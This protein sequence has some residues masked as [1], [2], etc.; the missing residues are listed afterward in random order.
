MVGFAAYEESGDAILPFLE[1][2]EF[3]G[4]VDAS[5]SVFFLMLGSSASFFEEVLVG[6]V[7]VGY[8]IA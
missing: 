6:V 3:S 7:P 2:E 5:S 1:T 4:E 8:A